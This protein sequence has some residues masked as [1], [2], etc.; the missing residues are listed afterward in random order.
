MRWEATAQPKCFTSCFAFI[1]CTTHFLYAAANERQRRHVLLWP[2]RGQLQ[3]A[4]HLPAA[5]G[6]LG[7]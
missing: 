3:A 5:R 7:A 2:P 1:V 6:V 4:A